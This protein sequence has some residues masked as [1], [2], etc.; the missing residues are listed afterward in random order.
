MSSA[1][2]PDLDHNSL[3][4][5]SESLVMNPGFDANANGWKAEDG[6]VVTW[7]RNGDENGNTSSGG[8]VVDNQNVIS[9]SFTMA[10][11]YQC[12]TVAPAATYAFVAEA[13]ILGGQPAAGAASATFF[14]YASSDCTGTLAGSAYANQVNAVG[15]CQMVA[16]SVQAPASAHSVA[17]RL[18]A[19]KPAAQPSM[20]VE[21][22]NVLFKLH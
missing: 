1:S 5:C 2:C 7:D 3:P 9:G 14:F 17:V 21:F 22:D 11:G 4:D 12:L 18:V 20:K 19:L 15:A 6:V 8:L 13:A 16:A 10:G